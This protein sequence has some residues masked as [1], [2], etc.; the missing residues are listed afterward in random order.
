VRDNE[1]FVAAQ[2]ISSRN[3]FKYGIPIFLSKA[4]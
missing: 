1:P 4:L 2:Q 3:F